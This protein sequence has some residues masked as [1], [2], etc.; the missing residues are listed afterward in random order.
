[1]S[2]ISDLSDWHYL[3]TFR[4]CT[5]TGTTSDLMQSSATRIITSGSSSR[6]SFLRRTAF[7]T[8]KAIDCCFGSNKACSEYVSKTRS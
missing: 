7:K 3:C 6:L 1:M 2:S 4:L 5:R 8:P